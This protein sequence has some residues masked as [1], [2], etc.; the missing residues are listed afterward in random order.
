[1]ERS[2]LELTGASAATAPAQGEPVRV[3]TKTY[4]PL[5]EAALR[6]HL[7]ALQYEVTQNAATE[8]PFQNA[9]FDNH[10]AG[11]YVDVATG[12][13]LFS[14][15][16]KF[17]SGTGWPSFVRPIEP[18]RVVR[19]EDM[20]HGMARTEVVSAGGSSHLGHV[21]DDGPAPTG[22]RYC[23][24]SAALR[25][26]PVADLVKEGYGAYAAAFGAG[27]ASALPPPATS[28]SCAFPPPG[29]T[30]GCSATLDV[31]IFA[32]APGDD[33]AA[34]PT[35]VLD[36]ARGLEGDT[37]AVKVSFDPSKIGYADVVAAWTRGRETGATVFARGDAQKT[38][39]KTTVLHIVDAVPFTEDAAP[40]QA[41]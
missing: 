6:A 31:A 39:V 16:D 7:S 26:V 40:S 1:M 14:S 34:R 17:E 2:E 32:R 12:E 8:P 24:N 29:A 25:F 36:V 35:G 21:F 37:P 11:I 18:G 9:Y 15:R 13:P 27:Q 4:A 10:R 38:A 33:A 3:S 22:L 20:T 5:P 23:I 28:N 19:H 41:P 30:P